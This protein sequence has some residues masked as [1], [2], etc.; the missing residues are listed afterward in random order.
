MKTLVLSAFGMVSA[1]V[2]GCESK[3][4]PLVKGCM[5]VCAK[6]T[7][8]TKGS[9]CKQGTC[10]AEAEPQAVSTASL[11]ERT[12]TADASGWWTA[13]TDDAGCPDQVCI[14]DGGGL[15]AT[16][17]AAGVTCDSS[18]GMAAYPTKR[19]VDGSDVTVCANTKLVDKDDGC[20]CTEDAGCAPQGLKVCDVDS[21][22]CLE[23]KVDADCTGGAGKC[24]EGECACWDDTHCKGA[25][26]KCMGGH[27]GC[28]SDAECAALAPGYLDKCTMGWCGCAS[29]A[30]CTLTKSNPGTTWRC[31]LP[32]Q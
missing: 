6:D 10:E 30:S 19:R 29:D 21:G 28:S 31:G 5:E 26:T 15:C 11:A 17:L 25:L 32:L 4:P 23:C 24:I 27:C 9:T 20:A 12:C 3:S 16:A 1:V 13:C 22:T 14:S 7:D 18:M 8:C 2:L